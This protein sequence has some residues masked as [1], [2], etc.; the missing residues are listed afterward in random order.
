MKVVV[1]T[2][3]SSGIGEEIAVRYA[4]RKCNLVLASRTGPQLNLVAA[5][6]NKVGALRVVTKIADVTSEDA[7]SDLMAYA[8]E[9]FGKIDLLVLNAGV[10]SHFLFDGEVDIGIYQ[11]LMKTNFFG[12]LNCTKH[13]W[14]HLQ[15]SKGQILVISSMSGEIGLCERTAYCASKFAVTGFFDALNMEQEDKA[16]ISRVSITVVCPPSVKT[17]MRAHSILPTLKKSDIQTPDDVD[18][19]MTIDECVSLIISAADKRVEKAYFPLK[20][21]LAIHARPLFP[22]IINPMIRRASKL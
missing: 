20:S 8:V 9:C 6:C 18:K 4:K 1:I 5:K 11:Q 14:P 2:G 12:Y 21:S 10:S 3:A 15:R 13:A 16:N 17:N 7:C 19:R 22:R